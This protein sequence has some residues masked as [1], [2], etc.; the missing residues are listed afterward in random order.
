M[1]IPTAPEVT[2]YG[3]FIK[4]AQDPTL[5][6][7]IKSITDPGFDAGTD[8]DTTTNWSVNAS[9]TAPADLGKPTDMTVSCAYALADRAKLQAII[10]KPG[11]ITV[12]YRTCNNRATGLK[13]VY[14]GAWLRSWTPQDASAGDQPTVQ[15]VIGIPGGSSCDWTDATAVTGYHP[16]GVLSELA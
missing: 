4:F 8:I 10:G 16:E 12:E 3:I 6:L 9:E 5:A 7:R 13:I 2:G 15:I 1:A 14:A 11:E